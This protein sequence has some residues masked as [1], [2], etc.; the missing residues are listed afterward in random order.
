MQLFCVDGMK[1][2]TTV[3]KNGCQFTGQ[4]NKS[5][6]IAV[7]LTASVVVNGHSD[8]THYFYHYTMDCT[9]TSIAMMHLYV[10]LIMWCTSQCGYSLGCN[11]TCSTYKR[12]G[13]LPGIALN[14][15][16]HERNLCYGRDL[17]FW[18]T[19]MNCYGAVRPLFCEN[20]CCLTSS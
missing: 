3:N 6:C 8:V 7:I 15:I 9:H 20:E 18:D 4:R 10:F 2:K 17:S 16:N 19:H 12:V 1:R 13:R 14:W 5:D 11:V